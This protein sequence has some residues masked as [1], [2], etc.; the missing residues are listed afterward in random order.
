MEST[1]SGIG[2]PEYWQILKR[3]WLPALAVCA[4]VV[5]LTTYGTLKEKAVYEAEGKLL[6]KKTTA[7]SALTELGKEIG[8]LTPAAEQSNPLTTEIELIRSVENIEKT[9]KRLQIKDEKNNQLKTQ[10]FLKKLTVA[11]I[12]GADILTVS[13]KHQNPKI[14]AD[15][16]KTMMNFYI[17][18]NQK[19]NR[20]EAVSVRQFIEKKLPNSD[21]AMRKAAAELSK[22]KEENKVVNLEEEAKSAVAVMAGLES[23]IDQAKSDLLKARAQSKAF[24]D[25]LQMNPQQAL[26]ASTLS[27]SSTVQEALKEYKQIER[28]LAIEQNR[29]QDNSP[30]I[31]RLETKK[32]TMKALLDQQ[33][34]QVLGGQQPLQNQSLQIGEVKPKLIEEFIKVDVERQG[35]AERVT[36]LSNALAGYKQRVKVLPKLE[37]EKREL[38]RK[39]Q[40]AEAD[41][42][43][44]QKKL[45]EI[46]ITENQQV[47]NA[48]IIQKPSVPEEPVRSRKSLL[49]VAGGLLGTLLGIAAALLLESQDKSV[50]TIEEARE[51]FGFTLL[52]V[53]P[54]HRK[55]EKN[56]RRNSWRLKSASQ[57][58]EQSPRQIVVR[59]TPHTSSSAAY[60]MLQANLRFLSSD[61]E[62]KVIVVSSS[63]PQEGKSTVS[64][65]LAVAIAQLGRK[66]L[67]VD[68]DMHCPVQHRIWELPNQV[69]LSNVIVGQ[70]GFGDA[71]AQVMDNLDVLTCGV[72]PPNPMALLDSQRIT[73]LIKQFSATYDAV[74]IDA[75][76]L[77]VAAD[78]LI[79]GN[80]A[81]GILLVVRPG[82]LHSG[83]VA[84]AKELLKKSSQHVLGL[85]VNG[86]S[87]KNEP[88]SHYYFTNESYA[89][90]QSPGINKITNNQ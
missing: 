89:Q 68:A 4:S 7:G 71:I 72:I 12:R 26:T 36:I 13:Y 11:T 28:Q 22:F 43:E 67:L 90:E 80:K 56:P 81:D 82:V 40:E 14:A 1:E 27:Q 34:Q 42:Q 29:Y 74:I 53:I 31:T 86:V 20:L 66:V 41:Y 60:R 79:L 21:Q 17:D 84:F 77:N 87:P 49:L 57:D 46:R 25:E 37:K 45:Q 3:R 47:G 58:L 2:F 5:A 61:K 33:I 83:T 39:L 62:L 48:R 8:Q 69:G 35:L 10:D 88:H 18:N 32:A 51:L 73:L 76:S 38:E 78:A 70:A 65:N 54:F 52:G 55:S 50:K 24:E 30:I 59:D 85:V 19:V 16:V 23:Q 9:I 75:P 44:L 6:F 63:L 15:V 64:A